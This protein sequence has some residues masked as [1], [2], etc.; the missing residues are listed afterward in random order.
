MR[1][2][3]FATLGP[4]PTPDVM[5]SLAY[6]AGADWNESRWNN[7]RF[8]ELLLAAKS[9]TDQGLRA[10]MYAEMQRLCRDDGGTI[11]PFFRNR[12]TARRANVAHAERIAAVWELDGARAYH[13]WWFE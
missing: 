8:N 1:C 9:E 3:K 7:P 4:R 12:T 5:F 10:E 11:V 13:R 6:R 2:C